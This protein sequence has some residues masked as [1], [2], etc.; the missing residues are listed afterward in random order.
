MSIMDYRS[1]ADNVLY[2]EIYRRA[3]LANQ[4][5]VI[6]PREMLPV[7][8][9]TLFHPISPGVLVTSQPPN[10]PVLRVGADILVADGPLE[11]VNPR[12]PPPTG[13]GSDLSNPQIATRIRQ[14]LLDSFKEYIN[15]LDH[16]VS[17]SFAYQDQTLF[18]ILYTDK[19][20]RLSQSL[21]NWPPE[22][23]K[24]ENHSVKFLPKDCEL[25]PE[26]GRTIKD[27][28]ITGPDYNSIW[29]ALQEAQKTLFPQHRNVICVTG[30][31]F[32]DRE[33]DIPCLKIYVHSKGYIPLGES[34]I[35]QRI[36]DIQTKIYEGRYHNLSGRAPPSGGTMT[37]ADPAGEYRYADPITPGVSIGILDKPYVGTLGALLTNPAS[38]DERYLLTNR[39][40]AID[41]CDPDLHGTVVQPG[42]TDY[43]REI[44]NRM[45]AE[46]RPEDERQQAINNPDF[47]RC[48]V[49]K[50]ATGSWQSR[51]FTSQKGETLMVGVDAAVVR[52]HTQRE[53]SARIEFRENY[54]LLPTVGHPGIVEL[55]S[56][57]DE[58]VD[59]IYKKGRTTG[60]TTGT[61]QRSPAGICN[62]GLGEYEQGATAG[63]TSFT[64][65]HDRDPSCINPE[66]HR[67]PPVPLLNQYLI[68]HNMM[69][70]VF[71]QQGDSGA[72]CY[73]RRGTERQLR[74]WGLLNGTLESKAYAYGIASPIDVVMDRV[75]PGLVL[76]GENPEL[77]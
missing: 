67:H 29:P 16:V 72:L 10:Q 43:K 15:R 41:V 7:P 55:G 26:F 19:M 52:L 38:P 13:G 11:S 36:L 66:E 37:Y 69:K 75:A 70:P 24:I 63:N 71:A 57:L 44:W 61:P 27:S 21:K 35:P 1:V 48:I 18:V 9:L 4:T 56:D 40:V 58:D 46:Q 76:M 50:V 32:K 60:M 6:N 59:R 30:G 23:V 45:S 51:N 68:V 20:N 39:H 33:V 2:E 12:D 31:Y 47:T 14:L 8:T 34:L 64:F 77:Q 5:L 54:T 62:R 28:Q 65:S 49:G 25:L 3:K 73:L 53:T 74:P 22:N 17:Y 42:G